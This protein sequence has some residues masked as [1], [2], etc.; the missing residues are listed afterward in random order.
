MVPMFSEQV[1]RDMLHLSL[2]EWYLIQVAFQYV[3]NLVEP[4]LDVLLNF[5]QCGGALVLAFNKCSEESSLYQL[6]E[7]CGEELFKEV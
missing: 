5:K 3:H 7:L 6:L 2:A 4:W 1:T